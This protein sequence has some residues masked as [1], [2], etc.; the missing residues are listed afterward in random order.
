MEK[1]KSTVT[2]GSRKALI[3][4][5]AADGWKLR[6]HLED[7]SVAADDLTTCSMRLL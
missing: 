2:G 4:R 3:P 7:I 1:T 5:V 6:C